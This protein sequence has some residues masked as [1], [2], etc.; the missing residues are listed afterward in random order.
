VNDDF[1]QLFPTM[2]DQVF[3]VWLYPLLYFYRI[4]VPSDTERAF[5]DVAW[6]PKFA[7]KTFYEWSRFQWS[8]HS[9]NCDL[10]LLH[11]E[12]VQRAQWIAEHVCRGADTPTANVKDTKQRFWACAAHIEQNR[13]TYTPVIGVTSAFGLHLIDGYHRLAAIIYHGPLEGLTLE[14][15][16][17]NSRGA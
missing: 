6:K 16:V 8:R 9:L 13:S 3:D 11:P 7:G 2:P 4:E 10:S 5:H 14:A 15:W 12:S 1:R 17:G